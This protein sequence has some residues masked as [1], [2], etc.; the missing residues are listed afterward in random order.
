VVVENR[1]KW[2][3][4]TCLLWGLVV[5]AVL[6]VVVSN[7][8]WG[9]TGGH[10][11][12]VIYPVG[13]VSITAL[14]STFRTLTSSKRVA[15]FADHVNIEGVVG[16]QSS[17][18]YGQLDLIPPD[19]KLQKFGMRRRAEGKSQEDWIH[20]SNPIVKTLDNNYLYDWLVRKLS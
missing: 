3:I 12:S 2:A 13:F 14:F 4:V 6:L 8:P 16:N 10:L 19:A 5:L 7:L 1:K 9:S 11:F 17:V 18:P 20:V 15:F